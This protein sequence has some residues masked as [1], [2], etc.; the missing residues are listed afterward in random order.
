[1]NVPQVLVP[2]ASMQLPPGCMPPPAAF[3]LVEHMLR[4]EPSTALLALAIKLLRGSMAVLA[5]VADHPSQG[6]QGEEQEPE[7]QQEQQ[8]AASSAVRDRQAGSA[9][10]TRLA[11]C[12]LATS[13]V[14]AVVKHHATLGEACGGELLALAAELVQNA[15]AQIT[16]S[17]AGAG[18]GNDITTSTSDKNHSS[19][20][21]GASGSTS[22]SSTST[23]SSSSGHHG[24]WSLAASLAAALAAGAYTAHLKLQAASAPTPD[25]Q[26][27]GRAPA[28]VEVQTDV[29]VKDAAAGSSG[30]GSTTSSRPAA[31]SDS[32]S[33]DNSTAGTHGCGHS[34]DGP[35][36][37]SACPLGCSTCNSAAMLFLTLRCL[38][39]GV[40]L[41]PAVQHKAAAWV[42]TLAD[43]AQQQGTTLQRLLQQQLLALA[44]RHPVPG[45]CGNV[46]CGRLKRPA[47]IGLV[48]NR[49]RTMCGR[50]KA[51]WY[52]CEACQRAAWAEHR[53]VCR[54]R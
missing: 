29:N 10:V 53:A 32:S 12:S 49:V 19:C 9:E 38:Q 33:G 27:H 26:L 25:Q 40:I 31:A 54:G 8:S 35:T 23:T 48:R 18:S 11:Y 5:P 22:T 46:L 30:S 13:V 41:P 37:A 1:M 15:T 4:D 47:A 51:A 20:V 28:G 44:W 21:D 2:H 42:G 3:F 16:S 50:C 52:C 7:Q 6:Q 17:S 43:A 36:G 45:V 24:S 34:N 39:R 14:Q